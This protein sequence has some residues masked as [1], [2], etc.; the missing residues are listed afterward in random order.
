MESAYLKLMNSA[1]EGKSFHINFQKKDLNINNKKYIENGNYV[2]KEELDLI[3][4]DDLKS[5]FPDLDLEKDAWEIVEELYKKYKYSLPEKNNYISYFRA[6]KSK[7]L[8]LDCL[9]KGESR[10]YCQAMLEG[11]ILLASLK[12]WLKIE[13]EWENQW[14][15]LGKNKDFIIFKEWIK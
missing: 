1:K 2:A 11:F 6:L 4:K 5:V 14:Y 3:S 15:Y 13:K 7:E 9:V 12:G 8:P 10:H